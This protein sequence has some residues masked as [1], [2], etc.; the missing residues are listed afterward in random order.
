MSA[1]VSLV[2]CKNINLQI[3]IIYFRVMYLGAFGYAPV[4]LS[5]LLVILKIATRLLHS[6]SRS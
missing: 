2:V 4:N 6:I 5:Y 3:R 1:S